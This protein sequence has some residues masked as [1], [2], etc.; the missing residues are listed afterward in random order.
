MRLMRKR[1]VDWAYHCR[2]LRENIDETFL[3]KS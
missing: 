1:E 2:M 3:L